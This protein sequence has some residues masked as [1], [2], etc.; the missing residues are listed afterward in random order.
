MLST[1]LFPI[2]LGVLVASSLLALI[3]NNKMKRVLGIAMVFCL[4]DAL[5]VPVMAQ[6][7]DGVKL[8]LSEKDFVGVKWTPKKWTNT[9]IENGE[10][11]ESPIPPNYFL[12]FNKGNT[13]TIQPF[14]GF[15]VWPK[16]DLDSYV[17]S[18][19]KLKDTI[20]FEAKISENKWNLNKLTINLKTAMTMDHT[21]KSEPEFG[22]PIRVIYSNTMKSEI[23]FYHSANGSLT[24]EGLSWCETTIDG[25]SLPRS[26]EMKIDAV[27]IRDPSTNVPN[28]PNPNNAGQP[29]D[30]KIPE[31]PFSKLTPSEKFDQEV[32]K[33]IVEIFEKNPDMWAIPLANRVLGLRNKHGNSPKWVAVEHYFFA[34]TLRY[35]FNNG[36]FPTFRAG[37]AV[38]LTSGYEA[39]APTLDLFRPINDRGSGQRGEF[40]ENIANWGAYG[41]IGWKP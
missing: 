30:P 13:N 21:V 32:L 37:V 25:E 17:S 41:L 5:S 35:L 29:G 15:H 24:A 22:K 33:E 2:S 10:V 20:S 14:H 7:A 34:R 19:R 31:D 1:I 40:T 3:G 36:Y 38:T 6:E 18:V 16:K 9:I 39:V 12:V 26:Q 23:N 8:P 28:Q 4:V 11:K 27:F